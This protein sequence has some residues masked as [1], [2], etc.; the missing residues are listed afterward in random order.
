MTTS[1]NQKTNKVENLDLVNQE[2]QKIVGELEKE[3]P[4]NREI[5]ESTSIL[6]FKILRIFEGY[7][8]PMMAKEI[9]KKLPEKPV[10]WFSDKLWSLRQKGLLESPSRG[11]YQFPQKK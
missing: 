1:E 2:I 3:I 9:Q 5:S 11:Y 7:G 6:E 4:K 10:K 8:K